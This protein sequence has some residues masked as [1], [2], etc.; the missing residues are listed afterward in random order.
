MAGSYAICSREL[1]VFGG[2]C[3]GRQTGGSSPSMI[4]V[5]DWRPC[6]VNTSGKRRLRL[7]Q[8]PS[9]AEDAGQIRGSGHLFRVQ[10]RSARRPRC[11]WRTRWPCLIFGPTVLWESSLCSRSTLVLMTESSFNSTLLR[12]LSSASMTTHELVPDFS[13]WSSLL[14]FL[15]PLASESALLSVL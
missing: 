1:S 6:L 5:H 12:F 11:D 13:F 3:A 10:T 7:P 8:I 14:R 2:R 15:P 9:G 4:A